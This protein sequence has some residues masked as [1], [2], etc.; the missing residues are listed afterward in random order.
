M[1][2]VIRRMGELNSEGILKAIEINASPYRLD[3]DWRLCK[4]AK[5]QN[6]P[7]CINPDAHDTNGL[8][9]V[10]YGVQIAR[11]GWL[12]RSDILNS[13]TSSEIESLF[14]H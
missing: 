3:L 12:E 10:W 14:N 2:A 7:I 13:R 1:H 11:K 4:F 6:V 8:E 9:D 5:E